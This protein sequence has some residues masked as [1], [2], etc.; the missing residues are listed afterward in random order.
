[1]NKKIKLV[2]LVAA[3]A[4]AAAVFAGC[5]GNKDEAQTSGSTNKVTYWASL[6]GNESQITSNRGETPFG[7][8]LMEKTGV[9]IEFQHP[10]QG[11]AAEKFNIMLAT[12]N[13]PDIIEYSWVKSYPGGPDKALNDGIIQELDLQNDAPNLNAYI[14]KNP[15]MEKFIKTDDGRFYGFPFIRGDEYLLTSAGPIVRQ[16]WLDDLGLQVPE[17]IDEWTTVLRAF[18][19]EKGARAPLTI[20]ISQIINYGPFIGAWDT[21]AGL[22]VRDNKVVYGPMD[23][24]FK[25]FLATM[26]EWYNEGLLDPDFASVDG[27]TM[28]SNILNGIS[29]AT[30]GSCGSCIGIWMA[31]APDDKFNLTGAKYPV[32]NKGDK[33]QFGN[34][35]FPVTGSKTAAITKNAKD[36]ALC[37]KLL[38]FAYSEEGSMLFNFGIEGESYTMVDGY[39][40]Y[41][42]EITKN[43]DGLSM[44]VSLARYALS[45]DTGAF[46]QDKRYMEQ[47]AQLPQQQA[48]LVTWGDTDMKEHLMPNVSLTTEQQNELA[49]VV[50]NISTYMSEMISKFIMG[51]EPIENFDEFRSQLKQRGLDKYLEYEQQAYD[52]FM[53]R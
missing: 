25:D 40:T 22:Y 53:S 13:L 12:G 42:E 36:K 50:E 17:T 11:Q 51:V 7:K 26:N 46:V 24:S 39:P 3:V 18:K 31:A 23:D 47:Y 14:Q 45:Q 44:A 20:G 32:V 27:A 1:M 5:G 6:S 48:A 9:E 8:A 2:A 15:D 16:D 30:Y 49:T 10:A 21:F 43:P 52:R 33:P 37:A 19:D 41:T 4:C 28:Q 38:D 34:Y 29:G 35:E